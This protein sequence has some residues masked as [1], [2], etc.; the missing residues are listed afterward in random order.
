MAVT[1]EKAAEKALKLLYLEVP[2]LY[3]IGSPYYINPEV[4][5]SIDKDVQLVCKYLQAYKTKD[6]RQQ[7]K[8][9]KI[10]KE[11]HAP[12]KFSTDPDLTHGICHSLLQEYMP[13]HVSGCKITQQLFV[14]YCM[15]V[16]VC[17]FRCMCVCVKYIYVCVYMHSN[18]S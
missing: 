16:F 10:Y 11:G 9:D 2:S 5:F 13:K 7:R 12:I 8:I 4:P 18:F 6:K 3:L 1:A 15:Y 14:R 17:V